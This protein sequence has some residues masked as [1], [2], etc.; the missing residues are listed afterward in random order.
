M[1]GVKEIG[2]YL[3]KLDKEFGIITQHR[4]IYSK[5]ASKSVKY[6]I[7]D[8][9]LT[10]WF[11]FFYKYNS[12]IESGNFAQLK[13]IVVRDYPTISGFMLE[14]YFRQRAKEEGR[15]TLIGNFW[16]KKGEHEIDIILVNE[17]DQSLRIGEIKRQAKNIEQHVL[18][19]K[20]EY[21]LSLYPQ[22]ASYEQELIMLSMQDM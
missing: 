9:L 6:A 3:S 8:N 13:D 2:G 15:Y 5:P 17:Q 11:R 10:I 20:A 19:E 16:D 14:R 22:L 21:F 1:I 12:Y 4:P 7:A 18:Q